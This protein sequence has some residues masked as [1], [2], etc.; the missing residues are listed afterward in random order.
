[1]RDFIQL[2]AFTSRRGQF[3]KDFLADSSLVL[4]RHRFRLLRATNSKILGKAKRP[5]AMEAASMRG[6]RFEPWF[7][8][9]LSGVPCQ[10]PR[11]HRRIFT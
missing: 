7:Y 10:N 8:F 5:P 11:S 6:R 2:S 4:P 3:I 9:E 1:V